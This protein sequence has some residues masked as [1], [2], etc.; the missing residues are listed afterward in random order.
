M[1]DVEVV[2]VPWLRGPVHDWLVIPGWLHQRLHDEGYEHE[3]K[4]ERPEDAA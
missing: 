2:R 1:S 3:H 4:A